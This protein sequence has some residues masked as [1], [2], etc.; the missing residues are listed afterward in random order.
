MCCIPPARGQSQHRAGRLRAG[1]RTHFTTADRSPGSA[2]LHPQPETPWENNPG[3]G[4]GEVRSIWSLCW[5]APSDQLN[6]D[7]GR[8]TKR[9]SR[10][11]LA[12]LAL[13]GRRDRSHRR[14]GHSLE[15]RELRKLF[16]EKPTKNQNLD[17]AKEPCYHMPNFYN[18]NT[19]SY[20]CNFKIPAMGYCAN[21]ALTSSPEAARDTAL[22]RRP[23]R[24]PTHRGPAVRPSD[25]LRNHL[26]DTL[27]PTALPLTTFLPLSL[28]P[29]GVRPWPLSTCDHLKPTQP[30]T[31][32]WPPFK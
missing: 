24:P 32:A 1:A 15:A 11:P 26:P 13:E 19:K 7:T 12:A 16:L 30:P 6:A 9:L 31:S 4:A 18:P 22:A 17:I 27:A 20:A 21:S 23:P 8:V 28:A 29:P 3:G 25:L 5:A 10:T 2:D 14:E